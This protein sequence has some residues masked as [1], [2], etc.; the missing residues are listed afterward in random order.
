[1]THKLGDVGDQV[2]LRLADLA[3]SVGAN[4]QP[5]QIVG[6][7]TELAHKDFA[8][9]IAACAYDRGAKFVDVWYVD[10]LVKRARIE[11]APEDTLDYV[12]PWYGA[13]VLE[14][15]E[16]RG[17]NITIRGTTAPG[18]LDGLD[19]KRIG[20]DQLP[21]I[22]ETS[23]VVN[24]RTVN[25]TIL[26]YPTLPWA[27][28]CYPQLDDDA[29]LARLWREVEHVSRLDEPDPLEAWEARIDSLERAAEAMND[30]G[31]DAVHFEGE[32]TDLTIGLFPTSTWRMAR[33]STV[34]G[35]RHLPNVPSEEVFTTPDPARVEGRVRSTKPLVLTDGTIV[36]GLEVRFEEGRA[37]EITADEGAE[38]LRGRA[39]L[40]EGACRLGE[41]ALV[42]R[43][44][45]IGQLG[46]VFYET[47]LDENAAS[48]IALGAGFSWAVESEEDRARVNQSAVHIDFMIGSD[49]VDVTG[50]TSDG[51]R[52]PVLRGGVWQLSPVHA[53]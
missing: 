2:L 12:P 48:H 34:D 18:A 29:A 24:E 20:R 41:V 50:I 35:I 51:E 33:W 6:V 36:R 25:W 27:R 31:L 28:L 47:L 16:Q 53:A 15:G 4:V 26:A 43:E 52:I 32:G 3:V 44:S 30:A 40:D 45:R 17:A 22:K 46:T 14:L 9:A 23:T 7:T 38:V 19:P 49:E 1:V 5:G 13:R 42:D 8:R 37:V 11:F 21:R 39:Q 10:P